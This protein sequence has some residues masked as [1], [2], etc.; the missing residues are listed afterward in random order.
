MK[1]IKGGPIVAK[2]PI[3][4]SSSDKSSQM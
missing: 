2:I 1:G 3:P 4:K